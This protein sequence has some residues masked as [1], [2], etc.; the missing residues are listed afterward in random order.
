M[1]IKTVFVKSKCATETCFHTSRE[2]EHKFCVAC[3]GSMEPEFIEVEEKTGIPVQQEDR[4]PCV[5]FVCPEQGCDERGWAP[6][7]SKPYPTFC[8]IHGKALI[9]N[10]WI[11]AGDW[12]YDTQD[13]AI[14]AQN[15]GEAINQRWIKLVEFLTA[16]KGMAWN[17]RKMTKEVIGD[18]W[19]FVFGASTAKF[20]QAKV[21]MGLVARTTLL[22]EAIKVFPKSI[23]QSFWPL[24]TKALA[25]TNEQ[26]REMTRS[27]GFLEKLE[28]EIDGIIGAVTGAIPMVLT[29]DLLVRAFALGTTTL[30]EGA[31]EWNHVQQ[32]KVGEISDEIMLETFK[33]FAEFDGHRVVHF[34]VHF[35]QWATAEHLTTPPKGPDFAMAA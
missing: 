33:D 26:E 10:E 12:R 20:D 19:G 27:A 24:F 29:T 35:C 4:R 30:I 14:W 7:G 6:E 3:G 2:V 18:F 16:H 9:Q 11:A 25:P 13:D 5:R 21:T 23:F 32:G 1:A 34:I 28:K 8:P 22:G 31:I 15:I 17:N